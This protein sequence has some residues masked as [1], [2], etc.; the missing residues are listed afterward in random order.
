MASSSSSLHSSA[1]PSLKLLASRKVFSSSLFHGFQ[2]HRRYR[3]IASFPSSHAT[4][5]MLFFCFHSFF[6]SR[7]SATVILSLR[8]SPWSLA[9]TWNSWSFCSC[10]I[11]FLLV[12]KMC[13]TFSTLH[14]YTQGTWFNMLLM[15]V[16]TS[17]NSHHGSNSHLHNYWIF[18]PFFLCLIL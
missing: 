14:R 15:R 7:Y 6:I 11:F 12:Y 13:C 2:R 5:S 8:F 1:S 10:R 4:S 18:L 17:C 3:F 9:L 16:P